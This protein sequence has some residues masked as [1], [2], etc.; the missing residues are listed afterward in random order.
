M[1]KESAHTGSVGNDVFSHE[2]M[3]PTLLAA[4]GV[5]TGCGP[6]S[7][8]IAEFTA[9]AVCWDVGIDRSALKSLFFML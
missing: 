5:P 3:F 8:G 7:F 2:V 9:G 6:M 1:L 4:A